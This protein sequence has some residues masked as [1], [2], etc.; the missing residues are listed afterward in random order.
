MLAY[1][2]WAH[3]AGSWS[4][5]FFSHCVRNCFFFCK[6]NRNQ[7][8]LILSQKSKNY[9]KLTLFV[10]SRTLL[11]LRR[12]TSESTLLIFCAITKDTFEWCFPVKSVSIFIAVS[13]DLSMPG[14]PSAFAISMG[15]FPIYLANVY[16]VSKL[17]LIFLDVLIHRYQPWQ[18]LSLRRSRV[19]R[20]HPYMSW[21]KSRL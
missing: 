16:S 19:L 7:T 1:S 18:E 11:L 21:Q 8:G 4:D 12:K 5:Q 14:I 2:W 6:K 13:Q 3:D 10:I 20:D 15:C 17:R 9:L